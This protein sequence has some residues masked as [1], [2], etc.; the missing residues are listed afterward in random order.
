MEQEFDLIIEE[1]YSKIITIKANNIDEAI[2]KAHKMYEE[3]KIKF[4]KVYDF[5]N[6]EIYY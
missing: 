1:N 2:E 5:V 4:D 6:Y 3:N